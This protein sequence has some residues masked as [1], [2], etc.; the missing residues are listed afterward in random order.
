MASLEESVEFANNPDPRAPCVLLLDTSGSMAG[1]SISALNEGLQT[2][3]RD[4][5]ADELASRRVEIAI[6]TFGYG[7]VGVVQDFVPASSFNPP[8]LMAG[9]DTPMGE[10]INQ[11]YLLTWYRVRG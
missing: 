7:G 10:A 11:G 6:I 1:R 3:K 4:L 9:G 5:C 8:T 2:L